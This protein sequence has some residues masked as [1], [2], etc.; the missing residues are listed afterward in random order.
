MFWLFI[1]QFLGKN[2]MSFPFREGGF[3][4]CTKQ[5]AE[6]AMFLSW[7]NNMAKGGRKAWQLGLD[8]QGGNVFESSSGGYQYIY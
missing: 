8:V 6:D 3:Y 7:G 2:D 5:K 4:K 1:T